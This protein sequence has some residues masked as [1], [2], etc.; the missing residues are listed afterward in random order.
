M[1]SSTQFFHLQSGINQQAITDRNFRNFVYIPIPKEKSDKEKM[2][3][4]IKSLIDEAKGLRENYDNKL[5]K[6]Q[7]EFLEIIS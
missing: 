2:I 4:S 3:K 1:M 7:D 5:K 6:I